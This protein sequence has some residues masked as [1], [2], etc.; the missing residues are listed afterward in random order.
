M[1]H[2][3]ERYDRHIISTTIVHQIARAACLVLMLGCVLA[4]QAFWQRVPS[5]DPPIA[6]VRTSPH[7]LPV[8]NVPPAVLSSSPLPQ[9]KAPDL[10]PALVPVPGPIERVPAAPPTAV[11]VAPLA[12]E[13]P[14]LVAVR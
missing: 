6:V 4:I 13:S 10:A 9:P 2:P 8:G 1:Y 5:D 14:P 3:N 12:N 7:P 11:I